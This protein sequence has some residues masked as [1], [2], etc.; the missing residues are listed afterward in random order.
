MILF[1]LFFTFSCLPIR[2]FVGLPV[3]WAW[4]QRTK[5]AKAH[6]SKAKTIEN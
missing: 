2:Y 6:T 4:P 1:H 5:K 3:L